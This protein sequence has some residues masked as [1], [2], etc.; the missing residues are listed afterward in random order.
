MYTLDLR[1]GLTD[2]FF[3]KGFKF[4]GGEIHFILKNPTAVYA[5]DKIKIISS[6]TNSDELMLLLLA[7]DT[8]RKDN[9]NEYLE[10][11]IPYMPYQQADRDFSLGESFSLKTITSILNS[12][13]VNKYVVFDAHSDVTPA[14]LKK[15]TN[16]DVSEMVK[17]ALYDIELKKNGSLVDSNFSG[18]S[19][20]LAILSPDAGAYKKVGKLCSKINWLGDLVAA[21]KYRSI[22]DGTIESLELSKDNFEGKDVLIVDDICV[23]GRTFVELAKKLREKNVGKLYLYIS[24]GVFSHGL[25]ELNQYFD[26]IYVTDSRKDFFND[27]DFTLLN[28]NEMYKL[29][30]LKL[31]NL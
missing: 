20:T 17:T 16:I 25:K 4:H 21:N 7:I 12:L 5:S 10:V 14:L 8:I 9:Y 18:I 30:V 6:I 3:Y 24:H 15:S 22:S 19:K 31:I 11:V 28:D 2:N 29:N 26:G 23:G 27:K 13:E 1:Q